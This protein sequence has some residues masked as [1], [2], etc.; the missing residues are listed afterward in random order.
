MSEETINI[1]N[2][3]VD[4]TCNIF[5]TKLK[6]LKSTT[7]ASLNSTRS[8]IISRNQYLVASNNELI[9]IKI[10][11]ANN[12]SSKKFS[13]IK[14][15]PSPVV[16]DDNLI[17]ETTINTKLRYEIQSISLNE[18]NDRVSAVDSKGNIW[19]SNV[20]GDN[21]SYNI[22]STVPVEK[23][24]SGLSFNPTD[25]DTVAQTHFFE[26]QVKIYQKDQLKQT[27]NLIQ[28]PTQISYFTPTGT[29]Q[30]LIAVTEFNQLSIFDPR[31]NQN[32][33]IQKFNT[34][35]NW[36]Y[37]I[38]SY[39][40]DYIAVGGA[41]RTV[42]VYDSRKWS[43]CGNWKN[44]LKY[45]II[46]IHFSDKNPSVC[47]VGGLDSEVLAGEWNGSSGVDHFTG[48]RVDSRWLGIS[49]LKNQELLFGFTAAGS[50]YWIDH[51]DKLFQSTVKKSTTTKSNKKENIDKIIDDENN[52]QSIPLSPKLEDLHPL[53]KAK[54]K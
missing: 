23:G 20:N 29:N 2:G 12:I 48:L 31:K 37:S 7:P 52:N 43:N 30:P 17:T 39:K 44:C 22:N 47:Y 14:G 38:G 33:P 9:D 4:N 1:N 21:Q 28:N 41:N 46:S 15:I 35:S 50:L 16:L 24:W 27:I 10:D 18:S 19:I 5:T 3:G 42:S 13:K 26:K 11:L 34:A 32:T 54:T 6:T 53:K 36:L 40:G 45:E 49:K 51:S 8:A 25:S